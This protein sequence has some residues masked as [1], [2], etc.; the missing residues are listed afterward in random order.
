MQDVTSWKVDHSAVD[1]VG[2][3]GLGARGKLT[4]HILTWPTTMVTS[5]GQE[6]RREIRGQSY[7]T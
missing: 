7:L 6:Q 3:V 1:G 2:V 4:L 5:F